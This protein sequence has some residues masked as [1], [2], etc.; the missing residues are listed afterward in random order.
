MN[1]K[2]ITNLEVLKS[3]PPD[4]IKVILNGYLGSENADPSTYIKYM[5]C[6]AIRIEP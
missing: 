1:Q 4:D 2:K 5:S 6:I 3:I